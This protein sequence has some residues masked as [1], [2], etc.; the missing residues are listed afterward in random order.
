M[1][2]WKPL[3]FVIPNHV[4]RSSIYPLPTTSLTRINQNLHRQIVYTTHQKFKIIVLY[5]AK[6]AIPLSFDCCL[7]HFL[8]E[9]CSSTLQIVL[10]LT[11]LL[12]HYLFYNFTL[13]LL[14]FNLATFFGFG[15]LFCLFTWFWPVH[16]YRLWFLPCPWRPCLVIHWLFII[17]HIL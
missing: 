6:G 11:C 14:F 15:C 4:P 13:K 17:F 8:L 16:G 3:W 5:F 7:H 1:E 12:R 9:L 2:S 10:M